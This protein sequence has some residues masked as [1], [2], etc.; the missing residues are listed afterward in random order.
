[1]SLPFDIAR[2][3]G[4]GFEDE[5]GDGWIWR[6]GCEDCRRREPGH[7]ERQAHMSPPEVIAFECAFRIPKGES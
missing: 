3:A 4:V 7:P 1:M 2:C 5:G 6:E